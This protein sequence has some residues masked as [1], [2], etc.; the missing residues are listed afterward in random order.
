M[1]VPG[2]LAVAHLAITS[3]GSPPIR[4]VRVRV[5]T[6]RAPKGWVGDP[7]VAGV[8][9]ISV[10]P[11]RDG[12]E[13]NLSVIDP[14]D[15]SLLLAA[16]V[17]MLRPT[18][19]D[20]GPLM[21]LGPGL[22]PEAV[23]LAGWLTD[24]ASIGSQPNAHLRRCDSLVISDEAALADLPRS[25]TIV[26]DGA[27]WRVDGE[28]RAVHIDPAVHRPV[29]RRSIPS[30]IVAEAVVDGGALILALPEGTVIVTGDLAPTDV[31]RLRSVSGVSARDP[32][33]ERWR[34][35]LE[36]SGVVVIDG[37]ADFPEPDDALA[38][39]SASVHARRSALRSTSPMGA[40]ASWPTVSVVLVTHRER[41]LDHALAQLAR[42]EYPRLQVVIGLHGVEVDDRTFD[43]LQNVHDVAVQRI[44]STTPFGAAL[45]LACDRADGTLVT[46]IDDDDHY[47][48]EHVW[49][50]VLA[51]MYSGAQLV[52]KALDWIHVEAEDITAFRPVY[53]AESF[54]TFVAGGTLLISKADL[55]AF[56]GWRP[57][58]KS[59]DRALIEQVKRAGGLIYRTHG[60][61]Y[62]Y[63]RHGDEHTAVVRDEHF[64][65]ENSSR[66][67]GLIS[68]EAFGTATP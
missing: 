60:L 51:R 19:L 33:P 6:W 4:S 42:I 8:T 53:P 15:P 54:A 10:R 32:L 18:N 39:Q 31:H 25:R 46:K 30:G 1:T 63:V 11:R 37:A 22:P 27:G 58:P 23:S 35:Q 36:A 52:G 68:H 41:F 7:R 5:G 48:P 61:G 12:V 34:A 26:V 49:D 47:A 57:V 38:W 24:A 59:V 29:G 43:A 17:R 45:Q 28:S 55:A 9:E 40:L 20:V 3:I 44:P 14:V 67:P 16:V 62:V 21:T 65:K 64:L 13:V 2:V 56:G 50:L 66:W